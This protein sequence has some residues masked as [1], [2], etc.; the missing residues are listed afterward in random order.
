M[1]LFTSNVEHFLLFWVNILWK[2]LI[3]EQKTKKTS[4]CLWSRVKREDNWAYLFRVSLQ[5]LEEQDRKALNMKE[6]LQREH[7][8]LKRRLEQ[9]SVSGSVERIRTDSMGSTISTDS[10]Q[11]NVGVKNIP[12]SAKTTCLQLCLRLSVQTVW[13][14]NV[15]PVVDAV[16]V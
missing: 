8:Y 1:N 5:K 15:L 6:Q 14:K 4:L 10:E 13:T 2:I 16:T 11:G 9:L 12:N 3:D 7:R